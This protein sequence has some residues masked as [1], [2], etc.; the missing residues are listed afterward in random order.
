MLAIT[1]RHALVLKLWQSFN[2][3]QAQH[4]SVVD[5]HSSRSENQLRYTV[6]GDLYIIRAEWFKTIIKNGKLF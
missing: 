4:H 1:E 2:S 3:G 6:T 5:L